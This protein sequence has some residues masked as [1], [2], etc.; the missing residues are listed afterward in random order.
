MSFFEF[1]HTRTYDSDLGWLIKEMQE[2]MET[3]DLQNAKIEAVEQLANDL[4]D[5][6]NN[7]FDNLDV[8]T[9]INNKIDQMVANG[10]FLSII[11]P[12][13]NNWTVSYL[14]QWIADYVSP[15]TSVVIDASLSIPGAAADAEAVG[16]A[17]ADRK[18]VEDYTVNNIVPDGYTTA[19]GCYITANGNTF[20]NQPDLSVLVFPIT[21]GV[22]YKV[23]KNTTS[24]MRIATGTNASPSAYDSYTYEVH[25]NA[26]SDD[27]LTITANPTDT[28]LY[29]QLYASSDASALKNNSVHLKTLVVARDEEYYDEKTASIQFFENPNLV[30][31]GYTEV[32]TVYPN[33]SAS[34]FRQQTGLGYIILRCKPD[35]Y[36]R[37]KKET[38]TVMRVV[39][40]C[41]SQPAYGDKITNGVQHSSAST[42]PLFIQSGPFDR[43]MYIQL[44]AGSDAA[45]LRNNAANISTLTVTEMT[46]YPPDVIPSAPDLYPYQLGTKNQISRNGWVGIYPSQSIPAYEAA[47]ANGVRIMLADLRI[48]SDGAMICWHDSDLSSN[49]VRHTDGTVLDATEKAQTVDSLTLAQLDTYDFGIYKGPSWGGMKV[50]RTSQFLEWCSKMNCW[51]FLEIKVALTVSQIASIAYWI[52]YYGMEKRVFVCNYYNNDT[53]AK[54]GE[55][56]TRLPD[57]HY[58]VANAWYDY[59]AA[60]PIAQ[61]YQS[62]GV[63]QVYLGFS[64]PEN[65]TGTIL[66]SIRNNSLK[67]WYSEI[68]SDADMQTFWN[69]YG[70]YYTLISSSYINLY[71]WIYN[72]YMVW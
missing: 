19:L 47:Y 6:V 5:F 67:L 34:E 45:Y 39:T 61:A 30:D 58:V 7:Y 57:A 35:T 25:H 63:P 46:E 52:K 37:I 53:V 55:W 29:V 27:P 28:Y 14:A 16:N 18:A 40:G 43:Y 65:L 17:I 41:L 62:A 4:K 8:Q 33:V 9:E 11:S 72:Y 44:Y 50:L 26:A 59:D 42:D 36:Y 24:I 49:Q 71:K 64:H 48:T 15:Q 51:A 20:G 23:W 66:A 54:A 2:V 70:D 21:G 3:V 56:T 10:T 68:Q 12:S 13:V 32:S 31:L 60:L 38:S 22:T 69:D 1:P